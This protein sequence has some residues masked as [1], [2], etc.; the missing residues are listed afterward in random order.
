MQHLDQI[1]KACKNQNLAAQRQLYE[2]FKDDLFLLSL[3][4]CRNK[5]EAQDNLHDVFIDIFK[6]IKRFNGT[7]S[8]QGWIK[9]MA[10]N[11]AIDKYKQKHETTLDYDNTTDIEIDT[12][13]AVETIPLNDL[14]E[15]I[16]NL[17]NQYRLVFN[18]YELDGYSHSEIAKLL[19][20]NVGTSKSNLHRAKQ[21]LQSQIKNLTNRKKQLQR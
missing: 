17:P 3:K 8:F 11:K 13:K 16:Q 2:L 18:L 9:R 6:H 20:I 19:N 10:I 21:L 1:I 12:D 14:L 5:E 15:L 7:G 4:Y